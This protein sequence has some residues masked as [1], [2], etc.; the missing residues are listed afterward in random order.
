M[1]PLH[2]L[3]TFSFRQIELPV[4]FDG[5][6]STEFQLVVVWDCVRPL[7]SSADCKKKELVLDFNVPS[8][9]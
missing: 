5:V 9:A 2:T 7:Q 1:N 6:T 4:K 3:K 8:A